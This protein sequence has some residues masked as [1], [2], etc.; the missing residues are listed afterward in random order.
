MP[1]SSTRYAVKHALALGDQSS[2]GDLKMRNA[3]CGQVLTVNCGCEE[4]EAVVAD[5]C[6]INTGTCGVNMISKTWDITVGRN[7]PHSTIAQCTVSLSS[8]KPIAGDKYQCHMNPFP[9]FNPVFPSKSYY[10]LGLFNTGGK[11]VQSATME[12]VQGKPYENT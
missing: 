9:D 6:D 12:G 4:V 3:L 8:T 5:T 11:L 10:N 1:G 7:K 2:L